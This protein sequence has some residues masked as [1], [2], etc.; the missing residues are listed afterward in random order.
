MGLPPH[1]ICFKDP[2]CSLWQQCES[3]TLTMAGWILQDRSKVLEFDEA[4]ILC[5]R[6]TG[7]WE[8]DAI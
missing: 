7:K 3:A 4:F 2:F 5:G 6:V 1:H 8:R